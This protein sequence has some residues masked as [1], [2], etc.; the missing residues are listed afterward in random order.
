MQLQE[1]D[2]A[3]TWWYNPS[4]FQNYHYKTYK[5]T[6]NGQGTAQSLMIKQPLEV[7]SLQPIQKAF[8]GK[9][10]VMFGILTSLDTSFWLCTKGTECLKYLDPLWIPEDR[11]YGPKA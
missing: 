2:R 4:K 11:V 3:Y 9:T 7:K 1:Y 6:V 10:F 5:Y 8:H